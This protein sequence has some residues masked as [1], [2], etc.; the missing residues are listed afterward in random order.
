MPT[1]QEWFRSR[2]TG[3]SGFVGNSNVGSKVGW[4]FIGLAVGTIF[5]P[6]ILAGFASGREYLKR[7]VEEGLK[8]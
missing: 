5:A 3:Q 7:R 8:G 4:F 6:P 1:Y 2:F